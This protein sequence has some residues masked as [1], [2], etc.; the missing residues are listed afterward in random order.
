MKRRTVECSLNLMKALYGLPDWSDWGYRFDWALF[1]WYF[2]GIF[3]IDGFRW[4]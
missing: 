4:E 2:F 3:G 1:G